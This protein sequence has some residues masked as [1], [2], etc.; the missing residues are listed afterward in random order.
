MLQA[1]NAYA[2][3]YLKTLD[4]S[5]KHLEQ[6]TKWYIMFEKFGFFTAATNTHSM[7]C[8]ES[9]YLAVKHFH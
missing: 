8:K 5:F 7:G 2:E 6:M 4:I 9:V 3:M 1:I